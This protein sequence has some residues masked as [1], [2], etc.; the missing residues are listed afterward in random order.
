MHDNESESIMYRREVSNNEDIL[1]SREIIERIEELKDEFREATGD[2]PDDYEMGEDDW[3]FGLGEEGAHELVALM[4]LAEEGEQYAADWEYGATLIRDSFFVQYAQDFA[5]D[6]GAL[7]RDAGWPAY[8]IDWE[9]AA[10]ELRMDYS[11]LDFD[12]IDYWVR[13]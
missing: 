2:E 1:D 11:L 3:A 6:I 10:R 7:P 8:C 9:R 13:S 5:E 12:G 4:E